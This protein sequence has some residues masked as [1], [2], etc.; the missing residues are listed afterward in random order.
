MRPL[1]EAGHVYIAN[2]PL[3]K[4][5]RSRTSG[6][7]I[8][9]DAKLDN[10]LLNNGFNGISV[11]NAA[12]EET[13]IDTVKEL[14]AIY[15]KVETAGAGL[16]RQ[17]IAPAEYFAAHNGSSFPTAL[18]SVREQD[19]SMSRSY[20][21]GA[22]DE[23]RM[24]AEAKERVGFVPSD[25]PGA[26]ADAV[27]AGLIDVIGIF[28]ASSCEEIAEELKKY[29]FTI[30]RVFGIGNGADALYKVATGDGTTEARSLEELFEA[31]RQNGKQGITIQ[32]Y[33]GLGEMN[34][35]QLWETTMDPKTRKMIK[36][37]I[38][39]AVEAERLFSLL[40]GDIVEPRREY[41]EL[42][43]AGVKDL[44]I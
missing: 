7:Y 36:V 10:F 11:S 9:T 34:P 18:I 22:E 8:D 6:E 25:E 2:P 37:S 21:Y 14:I 39:D 31:V 35:N 24:I 41:I 42:H 40:M 5:S 28:A 29:E 16:R 12:G 1:I 38:E 27:E 13:A 43:A 30:D 19:G 4:V 44:D 20:A 3:Y 26:P 33:K 17:G 32:R 23:N 15:R